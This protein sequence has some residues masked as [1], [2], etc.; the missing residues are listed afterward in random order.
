MRSNR[1]NQARSFRR[2]TFVQA[3]GI[4][5][6]GLSLPRLVESQA[7]AE[8]ASASPPPSARSC[9]MLYMIGGPSQHETFDMKP[10]ADERIRGEFSPIATS[11]PD[12][13]ICEYLPQLAQLTEQYS[14]VRSV[15]HDATFHAAGV[16]YNLTGMKHAPRAGQPLLD[17]RDAPSIGGVLQQLEGGRTQPMVDHSERRKRQSAPKVRLTVQNNHAL[18]AQLPAAVQLPM[19]IT[20]D[21]PGQEWAGQ[22]AGF[23]GP[24][25]DPLIMDYKGELPGTLPGSFVPGKQ[26]RGVRFQQRQKLL[27]MVDR[28]DWAG[29]TAVDRRWN[30]AQDE[31]L[32]VLR[33]AR[34]W[35]AFCIDDEKP[36]TRER[37]GDHHFGRS[38]LVARRLIEAGVRLVTVAW[39]ITPKTTHFD[40]HADN[41]P[42]MKKLLPVMD[43]G[44]SALLEDLRERS[45]LG[46][47]LVV[48]TGEFG[49][50]PVINPNG[51]RDHWGSVY[52]TLL[53]GGGIQGGRVYGSSDK[54]GAA[55]KD[56]PVH[57][58][59]FVATIYHAL[60]YD[61]NT[62]VVDFMG[63]PQFIV[64]G[65]PV[66]PLFA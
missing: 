30:L 47:T 64:E 54:N 16:H 1:L 51:G 53:A 27:R 25:Y 46:D 20:Q 50:T 26:N 21:G 55:P 12:I 56:N 22:H 7:A 57:V 2:R 63:R 52:S 61:G 35:Q 13:H 45:L 9:I 49:R 6:L 31:G 3:G 19:W 36:E 66:L 18:R 4:S 42:T 5:A 44:T 23:L 38:C 28:S 15:H 62:L 10:E 41:F 33:A 58:S 65:R 24:R 34:K 17:R 32:D 60:G 39:P 43:Q 37:Y 48:C 11:V 29:L 8:A 40:T 14:L 59:D